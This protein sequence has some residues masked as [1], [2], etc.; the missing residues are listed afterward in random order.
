VSN[1]KFMQNKVNTSSHVTYCFISH[2]MKWDL[3]KSSINVLSSHYWLVQYKAILII[4]FCPSIYSMLQTIFTKLNQN[5]HNSNI[6]QYICP[7]SG[8]SDAQI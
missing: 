8:I 7:L 3:Y 6:M 1:I 2:S 4:M 5:K